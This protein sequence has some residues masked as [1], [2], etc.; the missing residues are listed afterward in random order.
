[1]PDSQKL[2][3]NAACWC[4]SG[5][6]YKHC[7]FGRESE[8]PLPSA[9]LINASRQHFQRK[10]CLHPQAAQGLCNGIIDAHT[11]QRA[12]TLQ[13]LLD[14]QNHVLTFYPAE[15]DSEKLL[16]VHRRGWRKAS[17][18]AGFCGIH[19]SETFAPL[20]NEAFKFSPESAFLLSYRA[21]CHELYQKQAAGR[22]WPQLAPLLDRGFSQSEQRE[23]QRQ[24]E[25]RIAGNQKAVKELL[26]QKKWADQA[27]LAK[28][29]SDWCFV[30][31]EF[32]GPLCFATCGAPTPTI[33]LAGG[34][35]QTL[36]DRNDQLQH[37]YL[38]V[39]ASPIGV[40]VVFG[41]RKSF[42][43]PRQM[44]NHLLRVPEPSL[45]AYVAQYVFAHLENVCFSESWW[46][47]LDAK[48]KHH[49]RVLAGIGNPYYQPP[50]YT[51]DDFVP[52]KLITLHQHGLT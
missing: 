28:D 4:N 52:W 2:G 22:S 23:A 37:I 7:H 17:T 49:I 6:K 10:E 50:P 9:A 30:C 13:Q 39:I 19:D 1:M 8:Q 35:L 20:E 36:H 31:L 21:L 18:F 43:A 45:A 33:D 5:K 15:Y 44:L 41:W 42:T 29:Y 24:T 11:V 51:L 40:A 38:S 48:K 26:L 34:Q 32:E 27:L 16:K 47:M 14:N 25:I 12:R 46:N 3:R